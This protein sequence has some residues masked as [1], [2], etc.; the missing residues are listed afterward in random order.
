M[1]HDSEQAR[2]AEEIALPDCVAGI[3]RQGRVEDPRHL[4][5]PLQ[6]SRDGRRVRVMLAQP[7]RHGPYTAGR[8]VPPRTIA[9]TE[10]P[11][12]WSVSTIAWWGVVSLLAGG[13]VGAAIG[14]LSLLLPA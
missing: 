7:D 13:T 10:G 1:E 14:V 4:R 2:S 5:P 9:P 6:P 12:T 3:F 11:G 8:P